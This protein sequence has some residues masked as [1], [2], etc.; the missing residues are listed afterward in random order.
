M[1]GMVFEGGAVAVVGAVSRSVIHWAGLIL[2][3]LH[4][5]RGE[6]GGIGDVHIVSLYRIPSKPTT[7][8]LYGFWPVTDT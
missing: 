7:D 5:C 4:Y 8:I 2:Q 6:Q 1:G 3:I